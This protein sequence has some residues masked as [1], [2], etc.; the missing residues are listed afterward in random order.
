MTT[1]T[2][3]ISRY[4]DSTEY[5]EIREDLVFATSLINGPKIAI[6]CGC[7]AGADIG[8]L[9]NNGFTVYGFDIEP[10]SISRCRSR[11]Q[12]KENVFLTHSTFSTYEYPSA[13]LVVADASLFFCP[14]SEFE[15]V[16]SNIYHCLFQGGIFCGS[17]LGN[18]DTMAKPSE[19]PSVFWSD[20]TSFEESEVKQLL[21]CFDVL[22]F[23]THKS[24]GKTSQGTSHNWH[25]FQ[26]V[27]QKPNKSKQQGPSAGT[28]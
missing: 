3:E 23:K 13:S 27:A 18:E 11:F 15:E 17:F 8:Y 26:V 4:F 25:I 16:W 14:R 12:E 6:D 2:E 21:K 28:R 7:G 5:R 9:S 19:N 1:I 22:S 24:S 10:E 20:V